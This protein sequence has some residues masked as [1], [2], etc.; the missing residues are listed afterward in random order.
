MKDI[1]P[2]N[3]NDQISKLAKGEALNAFS[4][5]KKFSSKFNIV[6]EFGFS[7][8]ESILFTIH[9]AQYLVSKTGSNQRNFFLNN[10]FSDPIAITSSPCIDSEEEEKRNLIKSIASEAFEQTI[11]D[12]TR[13]V[14][15]KAREKGIS[16]RIRNSA[17]ILS[18]FFLHYP[19]DLKIIKRAIDNA[20]PHLK[21]PQA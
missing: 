6:K 20:K 10:S 8:D 4:I 12:V 5:A 7:F 15:E 13:I 11:S 1:E 16:Y 18:Y 3:Y 17:N 9:F 21:Q 19:H 14:E 2:R